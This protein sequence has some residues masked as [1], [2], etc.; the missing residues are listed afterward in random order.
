MLISSR[1]PWIRKGTLKILSHRAFLR[2]F[3]RP[4]HKIPPKSHP[5]L[6]ISIIFRGLYKTLKWKKKKMVDTRIRGP[7]FKGA[8]TTSR[9]GLGRPDFLGLCA[10]KIAFTRQKIRRTV[11][12]V[13]AAC[14]FL[15]EPEPKWMSCKWGFSLPSLIL[16]F[17]QF[18][19]PS[20]V[21]T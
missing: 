14:P 18:E 10:K 19:K 13:T 9:G 3:P 17:S 15:G 4:S 20:A 7:L 8:K 16:F 12:K 2:R 6:E 1:H 21:N 5:H 11:P